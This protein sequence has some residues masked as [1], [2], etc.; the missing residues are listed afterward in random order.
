MESIEGYDLE[1]NN[2]LTWYLGA[3]PDEIKIAWEN[4]KEKLEA[5]IIK[6]SK[7]LELLEIVQGKNERRTDA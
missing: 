6:Y 1:K 5:L 7:E 2:F 4:N 3:S